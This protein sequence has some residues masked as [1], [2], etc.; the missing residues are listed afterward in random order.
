M[1]CN[2]SMWPTSKRCAWARAALRMKN[3]YGKGALAIADLPG[4]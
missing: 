4:D 2:P 3:D 1:I